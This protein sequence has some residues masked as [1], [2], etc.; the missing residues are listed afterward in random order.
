MAQ[1]L[2]LCAKQAVRGVVY[3]WGLDAQ[4]TAGHSSAQLQAQT[5]Q[6]LGGALALVQGLERIE[7]KPALWWGSMGA[8]VV[9]SEASDVQVVQG[10]LWGFGRTV[11]AEAPELKSRLVDL[12]PGTENRGAARGAGARLCDADSPEGQ[13]AYRQGSFYGLRLV[14]RGQSSR[15]KRLQRPQGEAYRLQIEEKGVLSNL[16]LQA[17]PPLAP[18]PG[19]VAVQVRATGL[20]FRDVMNA[21]GTYPGDAGDLGGD[22]AGQVVAVGQGVTEVAVGD[23]VLGIGAGAFSSPVVTDARLV[24]RKPAQLSFEQAASIPTVFA[25]VHYGL[26]YLARLQAGERVLIHAAAGGVGLAA[27]Q[28]AQ[29]VG[30]EVIGSCGSEKKRR[31]LQR[32]GVEQLVNSRSLEFAEQVQQLTGGEGVAVVLNSLAGGFIDKSFEVLQRQGGRFVEIGKTGIWSEEQAQQ[33]VAGVGYHVLALDELCDSDP[34]LVGQLLSEVV[35]MFEAGQLRPLP[36]QRFELEATVEAFR[37][38][39]QG[40]HVGKVVV[41]HPVSEPFGAEGSYLITGGLGA[42]GLQVAEDLVAG[43]ARQVALMSRV[44]SA[45]QRGSKEALAQLRGA[46]G[47]RCWWC[48]GM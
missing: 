20:N 47:S 19:Q 7:D 46:R 17:G 43:G 3:L 40:R 48:R 33:A 35:G 23:E 27:V 13:L 28:L 44:W 26:N 6:V 4:L 29:R 42:L 18:G 34:E 45:Q 30:A 41:S 21:L 25:T 10:M 22:F 1:A 32:H 16:E 36:V 37:T 38:M 8:Q 2:T 14:R 5:Q 39:Q 12:D 15:T 9:G 31:L 11:A 24:V